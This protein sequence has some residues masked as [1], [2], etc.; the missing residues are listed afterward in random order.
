MSEKQT[1]KAKPLNIY[2]RLNAVRDA[3]K[4]LQK[5]KAVQGYKAIT[6]DAVTAACREH[7]IKHGVMI[8]PD[9]VSSLATDVGKTQSGATIIRYEARYNIRF[10]NIENPDDC[11]SMQ[12]EAHANDHGD[13][14]P[15]KALSYAVKYAMLKLLSIETGE[16]EESRVEIAKGLEPITAQ[17]A[18]EI[19]KRVESLGLDES[20]VIEWMR[21]TLKVSSYD[22]LNANG[23]RE[24]SRMLDKKEKESP[25]P[26][27]GGAE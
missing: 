7:L 12:I 16:N 22:D 25:T 23:Y 17:Q 20:K 8:V 2:Q 4:Y 5:D 24:L 15:G 26:N 18:T 19:A 13:K 27:Q 6:H 14:A 11:V 10:V 9:Q 3:V 21:R 1:Q